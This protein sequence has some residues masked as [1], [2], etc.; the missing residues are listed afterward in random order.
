MLHP[1]HHMVQSPLIQFLKSRRTAVV[2]VA[3]LLLALG[4]RLYGIDWDQGYGFH[5]DER[6]IYMQSDCMF[7]TLTHGPGYLDCPNLA[8]YPDMEPGVPGPGAFFDA[9]R[10]PLNPHWFPLGGIMIY[11]MVLIRSVIEPFGDFSGLDM[12][13]AGRTLSALAD[14][15][16]IYVLFLLGRRLFSPRVGLLAALLMAITVI[17]IQTSHF[18]RPETFIVLFL[19]ASFWFMLNAVQRRRQRD[20]L[21]LGLFVGLTFATKVSVLPL[22]LP[23]LLVYGFR[24]FTTAGGVPAIPTASQLYLTMRHAAL[25]AAV[26]VGVFVVLNPYAIIDLTEFISDTT[27]EAGIAR[28][29][30]KMPYTI[31]YI[32]SSP[33]IYELRQSTLWALGLPLGIA[34]W[35]GL[36]YAVYRTIGRKA[37][38]KAE[39]LLLAWV[40]P[41]FLLVGGFFEVKF[42]RYIFPIIPFLILFAARA[43]FALSDAAHT[44][45]ASLRD[46]DVPGSLWR[47]VGRH[48]PAFA[49]GLIVIVVAATALYTLGFMGI[50]SRPHPALAASDWINQNVP[51]SA[52]IITDNHWDEG[53]P[54]LYSYNVRQIPIYEGDTNSKMQSISQDLSRAEYL[55]FY[56]NRT[57]GSVTRVPDRFPLSAG[58]YRK[59]FSGELGYEFDRAFTSYP[60]LLGVAWQND[61]F[62]RATLPEPQAL[63]ESSPATLTLHLGYAD[64]NA[65]D[66]DHPAVLLFRNE[67]K[68]PQ[69]RIYDTIISAGAESRQPGL[70]LSQ[71]DL[72]A[73]RDGGTW[74][75]I[76][77]EDSWTNDV[78]VIAWIL[79]VELIYLVTLPLAFFIFRPLPDRGIILARILGILSAS[80]IVWLLASLHWL[81]FSRASMLVAILVLAGLSSLVLVFKRRDILSFLRSHWRLLAVGEALFLVAFL[82]FVAL[83]MANP[84]LWHPFRGGEKPMDFAYLNAILRSTYMPPFDP[85]FSGGYINYYYWGLFIVANFTKALGM[86]PAMA[87]N[88]AVPLFFALTVTAAYSLAFNV[89][90]GLRRVGKIPDA[91]PALRGVRATVVR[92]LKAPLVAGLLAALFV[93]VIA[94]LDGAV[95]LV[96]SSW[97]SVVRGE[98][99]G[100]FDFWRSS[101]MVPELA[102]QDPSPLTFW[103]DDRTVFP[104]DTFCGQGLRPDNTCPDVSPHITEFPF[105]TFLFADLHAHLIV[106]PFG[107]LV[108]GFALSFLVGLKSATLGWVLAT[109]PFLAVALG[110]LWVINTWDYPSYILL[111][112]AV[113][114]VGAHLMAGRADHIRRVWTFIGIAVSSIVL[115]IIVFLPFH[116][117]YETFG[118]LLSTTKWQT[119]IHNF[120]GIHGL[121]LVIIGA[122]LLYLNRRPLKS[123]FSFLLHR[124]AAL[125]QTAT[126]D[127]P[128]SLRLSWEAVV[129]PV[130]LTIIIYMAATG[131]W[132]AFLMMLFI[133]LAAMAIREEFARLDSGSGFI[134]FPVMVAGFAFLIVVGVDFVRVGDDIGRM[135]TLFKFYL[136]AWVLMALAA[137]VGLWY[138]GH[139]GLFDLERLAHFNYLVLAATVALTALAVIGLAFWTGLRVDWARSLD[140]FPRLDTLQ[141][142]SVL[143]IAVLGALLV[144]MAL[145]YSTRG[146][147][148]L[149]RWRYPKALL[150][151]LLAVLLFPS[152]TYTALGTRARLSDRFDTSETTLNGESFL[153]RAVHRE[154]E[155]EIELKWDYEAIRWLRAE[156]VGSPVV[157]EA[158]LDQYHWGGRFAIYTGL[159]TVIGWP[160]HQIQQRG[161][162]AF[163]VRRRAY[164]VREAYSTLDRRRTLEILQQY[165]VSYVVVGDLERVYYPQAGL[166]KFPGMV[167]RG[168][169]QLAYDNGHTAIYRVVTPTLASQP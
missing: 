42:L 145:F 55:V 29:A 74:S 10:S 132:T 118:A 94:N 116:L 75:G 22:F 64:E 162:N 32:G 124:L 99:F 76:V 103:L 143:A 40:V 20:W 84:D 16:S 88:L 156:A 121:F 160:W 104:D 97:T 89:A 164:D 122:F 111:M 61:T 36:L 24:L 70:M 73:Q 14:V 23:L 90:E 3:V 60:G 57:Y 152:F 9:D 158:H 155:Q 1:F 141:G 154:R 51:R 6:S 129:V 44:L 153:A 34:A 150:L 45:S 120:L 71:E 8:E 77:K 7:R 87:Y 106:I 79:L 65:T 69:H 33:F 159:P 11:L 95:Q 66:Y 85:W 101:R 96:E 12:R 114:S 56:S 92:W 4:L 53:I 139:R 28:V 48:S 98:S 146:Y 43:L 119:P 13:F 67:R 41:N 59:L 151:T 54:E 126:P 18:Y 110:A 50:Y 169:L 72:R 68:L 52:T 105:F 47:F 167:R 83:R 35:A 161:D 30:G 46:A 15:G 157:L 100:N 37:G 138:L 166:V 82:A 127:S 2:L 112:L 27:W 39:L 49:V 149:T 123:A 63:A 165:D 25:G 21:L 144:G 130:V 38:W 91:V 163:A 140:Q 168:Q 80:Y 62:D 102:D 113:L 107:L 148:L 125:R 5:P 135:N 26:A 137:A 19:L 128:F 17:H 86:L 136:E 131:Y 58:Y 117:R 109:V 31:Q 147:V 115:S 142:Y 134:L 81:S 78:P 108:L 133:G 93:C